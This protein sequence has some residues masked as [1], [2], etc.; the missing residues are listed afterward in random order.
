MYFFVLRLD[1]WNFFEIFYVIYL[2]EIVVIRY[3]LLDLNIM[4]VWMRIIFY[5]FKF[6]WV[7]VICLFVSKYFVYYFFL[8]IINDF[9]LGIKYFLSLLIF[10]EEII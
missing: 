10:Y 2:K 9:K 3:F 5:L 1:G 6:K 4:Y 7:N 8:K